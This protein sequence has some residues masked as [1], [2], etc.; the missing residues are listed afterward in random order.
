MKKE[1]DFDDIFKKGL[2]ESGGP[3]YREEDWNALAQMLDTPKKKLGIVFWIPVLSSAAILLIA[4]GWWVLR[5]ENGQNGTAKMQRQTIAK[6]QSQKGDTIKPAL[7]RRKEIGSADATDSNAG[8]QTGKDSYARASEKNRMG[9]ADVKS[10]NGEQIV[11]TGRHNTHHFKNKSTVLAP[12]LLATTEENGISNAHRPG[13]SKHHNNEARQ[14]G[15][16]DKNTDNGT[17]V[18]A[19][20]SEM[21]DTV[22]LVAY[23]PGLILD[24]N[25]R[26]SDA[27]SFSMLSANVVKKTT[28]LA[29]R[30]I[31]PVIKSG[32]LQPHYAL[33][34]LGAPEV[35]GVGSLSQTS[36]GTNLGVLFSVELFNKFFVS[37]G[38]MY[39]IKPYASNVAGYGYNPSLT[40]HSVASISA[41]CHVLDIPLNLDYQFYNKHLNALS[42]GTGLSSYIMLY[43]HY[44]YNYADPYVSSV[45]KTIP[46]TNKYLFGVLNLQ[47]TYTRQVAANVGLSLQPYMKLPLTGIGAT[48]ARLQTAGFAIGLN[49]N[50]RSSTKP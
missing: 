36:T 7:L 48:G 14:H 22:N 40:E 9:S 24:G 11:G 33:T 39:S 6:Q 4:F 37:T 12:D 50:L 31:K 19:V 32:G 49:W 23:K 41:N 20:S 42:V 17:A 18:N 2:G 13:K 43:E 38:G 15:E 26:I 25:G 47:A 27:N 5:P 21:R 34:V 30:H 16:P 1:K 3:V 10:A 8:K 45:D 46:Q 44:Q 35:N 29:L 28:L